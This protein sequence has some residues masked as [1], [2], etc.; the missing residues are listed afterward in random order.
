MINPATSTIHI[1]KR[2]LISESSFNNKLQGLND[3][4]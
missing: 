1:K 2:A 4:N 3:L